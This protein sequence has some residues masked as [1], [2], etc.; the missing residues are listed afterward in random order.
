MPNFQKFGGPATAVLLL[1]GLSCTLTGHEIPSGVPAAALNFSTAGSAIC[2]ARSIN[3]IT[4]S[5]PQQC[6][7]TGG[8]EVRPFAPLLMEE[9]G[10]STKDVASATSDDEK[11]DGLPLP[12]LQIPYI[13]PSASGNR[14]IEP[15]AN[16]A[17]RSAGGD[18]SSS[19]TKASAQS[20]TTVKTEL[21]GVGDSP[22]DEAHFLSFEEWKKQNLAKAGQ[23]LDNIAGRK[24]IGDRTSGRRP[25]AINNALDSL[26]EDTE[27]E[28]D[29]GGFVNP[30]S[31]APVVSPT[32]AASRTNESGE[33]PTMAEAKAGKKLPGAR[34]RSK[35]AGK[36]CKERFNYASFDCGAMVL[37]TNKECKGSTSVLVENK[38]SYMLNQCS[39]DNKFFIVELCDNILVD[40]IV[41]AN[42]EFFSSMFRTFRVSVSDQYP[43]KLEKWRE[44]GTF[45]ARNS[46]EVQ[47]FLVESPLIWARY[48]RVEFLA[49]YGSEYYCPVSLLRVHGTTMMEEFNHDMKGLR[50]DEEVDSETGEGTEEEVELTSDSGVVVADALKKEKSEPVPESAVQAVEETALLEVPQPIEISTSSNSIKTSNASEPRSLPI[51]WT[52]FEP[53]LK[54]RLQAIMK[55][56][57][58]EAAI[59][60]PE[61]WKLE[62]PSASPAAGPSQSKESLDTAHPLSLLVPSEIPVGDGTRSRPT[63]APAAES[64][65]PTETPEMIQTKETT[66][67][68]KIATST[69]SPSSKTQTPTQPPAA[70]PTTQESFFKTVHKR[71]QNL[72]ANSTLSLR[73]IEDQSRILRDAFNKVEKRQ[74]HKMTTFLESLN[75]TVLTE[76]R[77]LQA[78]Y[79]QLWQSTVLEFSAQRESSRQ[80]IMALSDR[81]S[82]L[83]DETLFQKRVAI[84]QSM[85]ILLCLSLIVFTRATS[86]SSSSFSSSSSSSRPS[87]PQD[88][89]Y[90]E[91]PSSPPS[92]RKKSSANLARNAQLQTPTS[93]PS[94]SRPSSGYGK[95]GRGQENFRSPS[96]ESRRKDGS[97]TK[98]VSGASN[99][100][101]KMIGRSN[102]IGDGG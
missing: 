71:L 34:V 39:A 55:S 13:M 15:N 2:P 29:F 58:D 81:L 24:E 62:R 6:L 14:A 19:A 78:Q 85:L 23:T 97:G 7:S 74:L 82:L 66:N 86:S 76:I 37:K 75:T 26:G 43:V 38:D 89:A 17:T 28:I 8:I 53:L 99:G 83:A 44:L 12:L 96:Q 69:S 36:T 30:G 56:L 54:I 46:R 70:N 94:S 88:A 1:G 41:L 11:A 59:C 57:T 27:I 45:E 60:A 9:T 67:S 18:S 61:D 93:S 64:I 77:D 63:A 16:L 52:V 65:V 47:A 98:N 50:G 35:D 20:A 95:S 72:E 90:A 68:A 92:S 91:F 79:D 87:T 10:L 100:G 40:T 73:Y 48:L 3:Y 84:F 101:E 31:I 51:E 4:D 42:F 5:L 22:L 21:D 49:H 102:S 33:R 80:E 25:T 32:G